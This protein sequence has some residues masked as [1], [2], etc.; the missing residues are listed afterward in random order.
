VIQWLNNVRNKSEMFLPQ[1]LKSFPRP[2]YGSRVL[3][4]RDTWITW[5]TEVETIKTA[6]LDYVNGY[7]AAWQS[8][9]ARSWAAA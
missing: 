3:T 8:P 7:T 4:S 9:W 2:R 5:I 6:E 1:T